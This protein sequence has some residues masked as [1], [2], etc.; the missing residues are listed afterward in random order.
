MQEN[1]LV[2]IRSPEIRRKRFKMCNYL[3]VSIENPVIKKSF[4][5]KRTIKQQ[6]IPLN[7]GFLEQNKDSLL[8]TCFSRN[9]D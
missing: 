5:N 6:M 1:F 8:S 3:T 2:Y 9:K 4:S 7:K